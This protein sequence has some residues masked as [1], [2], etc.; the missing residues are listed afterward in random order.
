[1][2][3]FRPRRCH[4]CGE[5]TIRLLAP[6]TVAIPTCDYCGS[7]WISPETAESLDRV[8]VSAESGGGLTGV[9]PDTGD[10]PEPTAFAYSPGMD[11]DPDSNGVSITCGDE[12]RAVRETL[13]ARDGEG[14]Q[15]AAIRLRDDLR[16]LEDEMQDIDEA[17]GML[18]GELAI[19]DPGSTVEVMRQAALA[20]TALRASRGKRGQ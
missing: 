1:M 19:D 3:E 7:E 20:I 15:E 12:I 4:G 9:E 13:L 17:R 18:C 11:D 8:P 2:S 5:G 14:A 16:Q 10:E 6:S